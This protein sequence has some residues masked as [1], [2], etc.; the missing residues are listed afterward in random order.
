MRNKLNIRPMWGK[1]ISP[2]LLTR[3]SVNGKSFILAT[4]EEN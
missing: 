1:K 4:K 2:G 3:P